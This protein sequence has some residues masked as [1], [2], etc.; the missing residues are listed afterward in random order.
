M[1]EPPPADTNLVPRARVTCLGVD[2][3]VERHHCTERKLEALDRSRKR[4]ASRNGRSTPSAS[5][6]VTAKVISLYVEVPP[7]P[8]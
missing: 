5:D 6:V 2:H 3:T 1:T 7:L 8:A 4:D